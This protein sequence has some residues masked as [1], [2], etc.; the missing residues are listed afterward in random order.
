MTTFIG[1]HRT[2]IEVVAAPTGSSVS[3]SSAQRSGSLDSVPTTW[4][5]RLSS[6][7]WRSWAKRWTGSAARDRNSPRA[8]RT[9]DASWDFRSVLAH[10][11]VVVDDEIVW[12]A[13][14]IDLPE[15]TTRIETML[16]ELDAGRTP[17]QD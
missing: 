8:S 11:Y 10:G 4:S 9:S 1:R 2:D 7:S 13:I 17:G 14:T 12:D 6:A 5:E 16:A 3:T 15:L